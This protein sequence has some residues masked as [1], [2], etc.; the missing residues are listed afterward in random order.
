MMGYIALAC[1]IMIEVGGTLCLR[2]AS[3]GRR[4]WWALVFVAY[5]IAFALLSVTLS[6]GV[7]L[8]V[9]YGIWTAAG[10]AL[11]AVLSSIL[12]KERLTWVMAAGILLIAA[13]VLCIE[14]GH[15]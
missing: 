2:M 14:L 8:A 12:F 13:G 3:N 10:V 15:A 4:S 5:I 11:T 1:A 9:A 6:L 7:P